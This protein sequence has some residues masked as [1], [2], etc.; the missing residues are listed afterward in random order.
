MSANVAIAG[1]TG[2]VGQ[3]FLSILEERDFPFTS[4]KMLQSIFA[5]NSPGHFTC[6]LP[7]PKEAIMRSE[8]PN[9]QAKD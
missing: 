2:A 4:M 7:S 1:V 6:S 5:Q 9:S 3:E 8:Q